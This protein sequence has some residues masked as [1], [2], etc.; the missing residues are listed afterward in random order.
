MSILIDSNVFSD[1]MRPRPDPRV[2]D[3]FKSVPVAQ[4][5]MSVL[6]VGEIRYGIQRLPMG[7]R[8][9]RLTAWLEDEVVATLGDR[10]LP[11]TLA[12]AERWGQLKAEA[13]RTLPVVDSM[14]AA[15]ALHH[16][17][18]LATRNTNDFVGLGLRLIDP[19][20]AA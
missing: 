8:R 12:V 18:D 13:G 9:D 16:G 20:A 6:T 19:F 15:T 7:V 10:I 3:F 14:I 4:Q 1:L 11:M 17:L 5:S 2:V